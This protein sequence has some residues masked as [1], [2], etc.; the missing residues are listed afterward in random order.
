MENTMASSN[1]Q[2]DAEYQALIKG[3]PEFCTQYMRACL[4]T[5]HSLPPKIVDKIDYLIKAGKK[6][7]LR[8]IPDSLIYKFHQLPLDIS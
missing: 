3:L 5:N 7:G 6:C 8:V 2:K 4:E 1:I